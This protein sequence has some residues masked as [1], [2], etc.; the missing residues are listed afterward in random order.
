MG[1]GISGL[2]AALK[3]QD[4][5]H[6][7]TV[8]EA[9]AYAGGHTN[10]VDVQLDDVR[11]PVDTGFIVFNKK[12]YPNFSSLLHELGVE[13]KDSEM[14]F[15]VTGPT[16][17]Y[18]GSS[19]NGLFAQRTNIGRPSHY[20]MLVDILRFNKIAS[21]Q[22]PLPT[23]TLGDFVARNG[24]CGPFLSAYLFPM[25]AAIWSA[26][27]SD[28]SQFPALY[29]VRFFRNHG[30][31]QL[32][33]RP[34]WLTIEGGARTYVEAILNKL[35][36]N[37]RLNTAA[38]RIS[39]TSDYVEIHAN[40][41]AE[42]FHW[43]VIACHSDQALKLLSEPSSLEDEILS[44]LPYSTNE[45]VL[46]WDQRLL[47]KR[48]RAW[49]AW[50]YLLQ[51]G[52]INR[53]VV[54]Y[55][56]NILQSLPFKKQCLVTLNADGEIDPEKVIKRFTYHHPSYNLQSHRAQQRRSEISGQNRTSYCGAYWGY[57]FHEDGVVS[58]LKR[59]R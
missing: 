25:A 4:R 52:D 11:Y 23:E 49:A 40:G 8:F 17:E 51:R 2:V 9:N 18:S 59:N 56:L 32:R 31:L 24:F 55:N 45:A 26:N 14:S 54:T 46:H 39:R 15:A 13:Y 53:V 21:T 42:Q 36:E 20:R 43:V 48:P 30:L 12:N 6:D 19:L 27:V 47:P 5:G 10:T 57:G 33:D 38:S 58:A 37:L 22:D 41:V 28:I 3:L 7:V 16:T 29:L 50:N 35:G 1:A 44:A 34:Q